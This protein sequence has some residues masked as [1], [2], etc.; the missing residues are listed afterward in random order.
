MT[1]ETEAVKETAKAA[2]EIAKTTGKAIDASEK[3]G[4]F[5]SR[6]ISGPLEQGMGIFEDKLKYMRWERQMRLME[7]AS[8]YMKSIG[9]EAPTKP[10]PLKLAIPLLEAASLE[11]D[12][13]LQDLWAKL[14]VNSSIKG[15]PIDLNRSYIDILERLS[16]LEATILSVIYALP[17]EE[18]RNKSIL[19]GN[20]PD[21][22]EV[23]DENNK[24]EPKLPSKEVTLALANLARLG[25]ISLP[26]TVGGGELFST[27]YPAVMGRSLV[28][29][30]TLQQ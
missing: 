9:I 14:L 26:T 29:A 5:V 1:E 15:S 22:V 4:G 2:Q 24:E 10:I 28:E 19:T 23:Q 21:S 8:A 25:C 12:D 3:F 18:I 11:D 30:C 13:Y 27:I 7:R 16:H 17:K 20:L 6:Y